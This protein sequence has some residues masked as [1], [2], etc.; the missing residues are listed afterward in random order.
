MKFLFISCLLIAVT[1]ADHF[2]EHRGSC[3]GSG[4]VTPSP[5]KA[6]SLFHFNNWRI[7][8]IIKSCTVN[9]CFEQCQYR[10]ERTAG[11]HG[12][13]FRLSQINQ[14][15]LMM[16]PITNVNTQ[17]KEVKCSRIFRNSN[18]KITTKPYGGVFSPR[19]KTACA[20]RGK[21]TQ[22]YLAYGRCQ[23]SC[24]EHEPCKGVKYIESNRKC[25]LCDAFPVMK[26][27][28][29]SNEATCAYYFRPGNWKEKYYSHNP[30]VPWATL[31]WATLNTT[32]TNKTNLPDQGS[33]DTTHTNK[34]NLLDQGSSGASSVSLNVSTL[35]VVVFASLFL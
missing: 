24:V 34:T 6:I 26:V 7:S 11:C 2:E 17:T 19:T 13:E 29:T 20:C 18:T 22:G 32:H 5:N 23:E 30:H 35:L 25:T 1:Y 9:R 27:I 16:A 8:L 10:C 28:S 4:G 15:T 12:T 21:V 33:S 3:L 14:C 31:N